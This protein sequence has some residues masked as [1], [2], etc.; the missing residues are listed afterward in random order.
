MGKMQPPLVIAIGVAFLVV[1]F[2]LV[3]G[4][5][6]KEELSVAWVVAAVVIVLA[7]LSFRLVEVVAPVVG[8][9]YTPSAVFFLAIVFLLVLNLHLSVKLTRLEDDR[10]KMAQTIALLEERTRRP[11]ETRDG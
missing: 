10:T 2:W 7:T 9:V 3:R 11:A 6:L 5:R 4:R 1:V 8:A